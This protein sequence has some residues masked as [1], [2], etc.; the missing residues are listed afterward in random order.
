MW[1][2]REEDAASVYGY[3]DTL[4]ANNLGTMS[5]QAMEEDVASVYGYYRY[6]MSNIQVELNGR[7]AAASAWLHRYT[8]SK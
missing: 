8:M 5:G 3:T 6:T 1:R 2:A 7:A 4:R